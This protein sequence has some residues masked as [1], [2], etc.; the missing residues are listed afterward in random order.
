ME[1]H[2]PVLPRIG[3]GQVNSRPLP[4]SINDPYEDDREMTEQ[5][6]S[7]PLY[8]GKGSPYSYGSI[9]DVA[10]SNQ[11]MAGERTDMEFSQ[12]R[13]KTASIAGIGQPSLAFV[14]VSY[15][16]P[17]GLLSRKKEK[18]ILNSLR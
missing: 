14:D 4:L 9:G 12:E 18:V 17:P 8:G 15:I 3:P 7:Q 11:V 5:D 1:S 6:V 16:I 10:H 13:A 2:A